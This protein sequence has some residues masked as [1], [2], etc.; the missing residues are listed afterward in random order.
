MGFNLKEVLENEK[1]KYLDKFEKVNREIYL[2]RKERGLYLVGEFKRNI[3]FLDL[4]KLTLNY[5][6]FSKQGR[7]QG[8]K[9]AGFIAPV[10]E[11]FKIDKYKSIDFKVKLYIKKLLTKKLTAPQIQERLQEKDVKVSTMFVSL[12]L[13]DKN[14]WKESNP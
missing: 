7:S 4:G 2:Q 12:V 3:I 11:Y 10:L 9:R 1:K 14:F 8:Q 13:N 6:L 5:Y